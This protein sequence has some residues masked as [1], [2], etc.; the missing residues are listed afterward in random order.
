MQPTTQPSLPSKRP[1]VLAT[2]ADYWLISF[3][4]NELK[5]DFR[6]T[7]IEPRAAKAPSIAA[8]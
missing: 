6:H 7:E 3:G 2:P 5:P 8:Q 4:D 1:K